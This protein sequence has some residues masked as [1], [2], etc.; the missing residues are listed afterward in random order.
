V[1]SNEQCF[2]LGCVFALAAGIVFRLAMKKRPDSPGCGRLVADFVAGTFML[3]FFF[4][5]VIG[6]WERYGITRIVDREHP[7]P[8]GLGGFYLLAIAILLSVLL[9]PVWM[10]FIYRRKQPYN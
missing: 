2:I 1:L 3:T 5:V 4:S 9:T 7:L 6:I 10:W 8:S